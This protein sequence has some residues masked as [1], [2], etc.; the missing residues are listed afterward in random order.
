MNDLTDDEIEQYEQVLEDTSV[1]SLLIEQNAI[2]RALYS[3]IAQGESEAEAQYKCESCGS[4]YPKSD[5]E[6][7]LIQQ[8]NAPPGGQIDVMDMFDKVER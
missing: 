6:T 4:V 2:L 7:H 1:K 8:H 3:E 5:L